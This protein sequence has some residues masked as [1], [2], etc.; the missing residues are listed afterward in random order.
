MKK[1][2]LTAFVA[3]IL[4]SLTPCDAQIPP[5]QLNR[6]SPSSPVTAGPPVGVAQPPP[7]NAQK[8]AAASSPAGASAATIAPPA[9]I[10]S[11][12]AKEVL[13]ANNQVVSQVASMYQN[14]GLFITIIVTL[15]GGIAIWVSYVARKSVQ[16]FIQ[17]WTKKM[18]S[19]E[20]DMKED[21]KRLRDAV[22]EA[23]G[24]AKKA[25]GHAQSIEDSKEIVSKILE[26]YDRLRAIPTFS[27]QFR[28]EEEVA[29]SPQPV[30]E[31]PLAQPPQG[32]LATEEDAE[33]ADRLK[34]KI[35]TPEGEGQEP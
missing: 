17:E 11:L 7:V 5:P 9:D 31:T 28:G 32:P 16:E 8:A 14:F 4:A 34:G 33:V 1:P 26:D 27:A 23:E 6:S 19:I 13:S 3:V 20:N 2:I 12:I 21:L 15:V 24:S 22:A 10:A 35:D 25:G 30:A 18:E 29:V